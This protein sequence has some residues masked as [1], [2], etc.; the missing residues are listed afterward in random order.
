VSV[1]DYETGTDA[2][3]RA[4]DEAL[5]RARRADSVILVE[6]ISDQIALETMAQRLGRD[7]EAE[8][9]VVVPIG[10]AHAVRNV[11]AEFEDRPAVRF[12]GL[13][14]EAEADLF[15]RA[16]EA[17]P[18]FE[19]T[20]IHVCVRD[21]ED[22]LIRALAPHH[23]ESLLAE[24]G[25]LSSFRTMQKQPSWRDEPVEAQMHRWLRS[26]SGRTNRYADRV[27]RCSDARLPGPLVAAIELA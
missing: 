2:G 27:L 19:V 16:A 7:L 6:G 9:I 14:D 26:I 24:A 1:R 8:R 13:V 20:R 5:A 15:V 12:S 10:G 25:D 22:E 18:T 21:L 11:V 3:I 17:C 4:T 23:F